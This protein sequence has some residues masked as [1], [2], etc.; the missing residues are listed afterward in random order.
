[1]F[2]GP[3]PRRSTDAGNWNRWQALSAYLPSSVLQTAVAVILVY[4]VSSMYR[5]KTLAYQR[6]SYRAQY[7]LDQSIRSTLRAYH[8]I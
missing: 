6:R 5:A 8:S 4:E 3:Q 1:M 7:L 2:H